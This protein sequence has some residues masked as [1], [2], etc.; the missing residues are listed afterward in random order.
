MLPSRRFN[1]QYGLTDFFN[2]FFE[3]KALEKV[4]GTAP[5][6]NVMENEKEYRL[7]VAVP[8]MCKDDFKVHLN[9]DGNLVIEMEK[10]DCGCK[11]KEKDEDKKEC[12]YLRK[13]FSY[14]KFSQTLLLPDN[15]DKE[16]IEAQVN[17]GVLKVVIPKLEKVKV[18][19]EKRMIEVK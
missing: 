15:A 12:R 1:S 6:M 7:E 5:A 19:D 18:E 13:E 10:K 4:T 16:K 8:G 14:S 2:D 9:K 17:N 3:N 11:N